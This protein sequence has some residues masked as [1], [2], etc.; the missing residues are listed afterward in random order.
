MARVSARKHFL[1]TQ[2]GKWPKSVSEIQRNIRKIRVEC[3]IPLQLTEP[4]SQ[5]ASYQE[6]IH[7]RSKLP[8]T[9]SQTFANKVGAGGGNWVGFHTTIRL[10][11]TTNKST[12]KPKRLHEQ[13]KPSEAAQLS[14]QTL[15]DWS[16]RH[17]GPNLNKV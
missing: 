5:S 7:N 10:N 13:V 14:G 17:E 3:R 2:Q 6:A 4:V 8:E 11:P 1:Q 15:N 16:K 12:G 9:Q